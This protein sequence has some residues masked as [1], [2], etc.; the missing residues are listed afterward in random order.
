MR[1][2]LCGARIAA[3]EL[4]SDVSARFAERHAQHD[5]QASLSPTRGGVA[6]GHERNVLSAKSRRARA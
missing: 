1:R 2:R 5:L 4:S 6:A 3:Y